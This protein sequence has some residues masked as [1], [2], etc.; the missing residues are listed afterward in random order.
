MPNFVVRMKHTTATNMASWIDN[1]NLVT[2]Y[3]NATYQ[4]STT[5]W[6]ML[7]LTNP[8]TWNGTDNILVD[9]AFGLIGSYNASGTVQ[10]STV[11]SGYRFTRSDSADQTSVF[12]GGS[13][14]TTRPNLSS[15][16]LRCPPHPRS[17]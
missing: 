6:N 17:T 9:T 7:T 3:S 12:T 1:S 8:F 16:L 2:V 14:A 10:Y 11:T 4:P 5:G 15:P 13:T